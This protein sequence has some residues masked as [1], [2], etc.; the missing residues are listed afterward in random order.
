VYIHT[1]DVLCGLGLLSA[2]SADHKGVKFSGATIDFYVLTRTVQE[3]LGRSL[4]DG[5][6]MLGL[7]MWGSVMFSMTPPTNFPDWVA[8]LQLKYLHVAE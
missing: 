3:S 8:S 7:Y 4:R 6:V 1:S 2:A 5:S